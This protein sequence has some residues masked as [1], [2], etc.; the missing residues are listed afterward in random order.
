MLN[1]EA[2]VPIL[3]TKQKQ[4]LIQYF[5]NIHGPVRAPSGPRQDPYCTTN[6][7]KK[8]KDLEKMFVTTNLDFGFSFCKINGGEKKS[9]TYYVFL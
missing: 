2:A 8:E 5:R 1:F 6:K 7:K 3:F 9:N 4:G